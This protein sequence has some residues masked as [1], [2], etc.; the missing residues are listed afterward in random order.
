MRQMQYISSPS[1]TRLNQEYVR[2]KYSL[3]LV[4]TSIGSGGY[5]NTNEVI[6]PV[7]YQRR[8]TNKES[9]I[10]KSVNKM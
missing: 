3:P 6:M 4:E 1:K 8:S 10:D 2:E 7:L 5:D 9:S